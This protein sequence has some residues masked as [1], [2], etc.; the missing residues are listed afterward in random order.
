MYSIS[1]SGR[2]RFGFK[3]VRISS[4]SMKCRRCNKIFLQSNNFILKL[5]VLLMGTHFNL[6]K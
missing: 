1:Q 4:A 3:A 2:Y 6:E 5:S